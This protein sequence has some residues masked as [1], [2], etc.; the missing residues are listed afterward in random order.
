MTTHVAFLRGINLGKRQIKMADLK[1]CF[2]SM[3][4]KGV[5]TLL[6]SGNVLFD[7]PGANVAAKIENGLEKCFG[8]PVGVVLRSCEELRRLVKAKPFGQ[9]VENDNT[10]LY[11][12]FLAEHVAGTLPM[13][14]RVEGDF[15]VV[16]LTDRE[17]FHAGYRTPNGRF[18]PGGDV[19]GKHFEKRT[20]WTTRNW[21][22]VLKAVQGR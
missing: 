4:F 15:E 10:K 8:F 11:A 12:T 19:I 2:E 6:A 18:G 3:G 21:N 17:V 16:K 7:A 5:A 13:P 22:T 9:L 20:L 14:C 1:A